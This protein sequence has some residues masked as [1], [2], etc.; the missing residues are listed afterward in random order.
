MGCRSSQQAPFRRLGLVSSAA[1]DFQR[2]IKKYKSSS[3]IGHVRYSTLGK[4][5]LENAQP[6]KVK[7]LCV[8]HNGTIAN[9][10]ELSGVVGGCQLFTPQTMSDTLV[11]AQRLVM[12]LAEKDDM[13]EAI[14]I[15]KGEMVGS[16]LLYISDRRRFCICC[17]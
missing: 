2:V 5:T 15:L 9:V 17:T 13:A 16:F 11:A 6:L 14:H 3:A 10:E 8:A 1:S 7:D 12:H 4:S